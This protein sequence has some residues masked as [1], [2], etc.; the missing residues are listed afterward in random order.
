MNQCDSA[1]F[2]V[3]AAACHPED[4]L[5]T[6]EH[7]VKVKAQASGP[8]FV[9]VPRERADYEPLQEGRR[10]GGPREQDERAEGQVLAH[11]GKQ[12]GQQGGQAGACGAGL[13]M[14]VLGAALSSSR[15]GQTRLVV[16][17][18][19]LVEH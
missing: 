11:L 19:R 18:L 15:W 14:E 17:T 3:F 12:V 7:I 8:A 2:T 4:P 16:K 9:P 5:W 13:R 6:T 10:V 1:Y